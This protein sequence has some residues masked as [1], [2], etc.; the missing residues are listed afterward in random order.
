[1][2]KIYIK[3]IVI[4]LIVLFIIGL[5]VE[6]FAADDIDGVISG[7]KSFVSEANSDKIDTTK[8]Q[9]TSNMIYNT[10]LTI[11]IAVAVIYASVLGT[12]FMMASAEGKAE[13][14]ESLMPFVIGCIVVFSAFA[15]WKAMVLFLKTL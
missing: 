10:L 13:L 1:M 6:G 8:M 5:N 4:I 9:N 14:K 12:K 15:I 3:R 2:K 7:G 11:A